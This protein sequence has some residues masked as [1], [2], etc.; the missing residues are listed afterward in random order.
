[1]TV[2]D[3]FEHTMSLIDE[4]L[5]SGL[6][7]ATSTA[8][9][10]KNTP[11]LLTILQNEV[12]QDSDYTKTETITVTSAVPT[13]DGWIAHTMPSDFK[14]EKQIVSIEADGTYRNE[15]DFKWQGN[16]VLLIPDTFI[17]TIRVIYTPIPDALTA[18]TD[19]MVVD[20]LICTTILTYGLASRLLTNE[21]KALASFF[22]QLYE[23]AR[24]RPKKR[25]LAYAET[26]IDKHDSKMSY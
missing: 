14:N 5:D 23:E 24:N 13:T 1:M 2:N 11:Y 21:N 12:I 7:D 17:G 22:N 16:N 4:R 6:V 18:L 8:I 15:S 19:N 9:F 10:K 26:I 25:K 3:I 20:N